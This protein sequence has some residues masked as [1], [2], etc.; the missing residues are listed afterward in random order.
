[1][2]GAFTDW[3]GTTFINNPVI[4][5]VRCLV[6]SVLSLR[7]NVRYIT[8][9]DCSL[10][11]HVINLILYL[12]LRGPGSSVGIDWLRAGRS[13][14]RIPVAASMSAH[15]QTGPGAHSASCTMGTWSF[16]WVESGRGVTLTPHLLVLR[17]KNR[18]ELYLYSP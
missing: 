11:N 18:V 9:R 4:I 7:Y 12:T 16:P 1:M 13:G 8:I 10:I 2:S 3:S 17:S 15:V 5:T 6:H 14:A